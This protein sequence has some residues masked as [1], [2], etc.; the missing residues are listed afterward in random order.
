MENN[1]L[2]PRDGKID[3]VNVKTGG[4]MVDGSKELVSMISDN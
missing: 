3:K 1:I 4:D 2:S